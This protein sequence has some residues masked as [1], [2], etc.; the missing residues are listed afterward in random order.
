MLSYFTFRVESRTSFMTLTL[1]CHFRVLLRCTAWRPLGPMTGFIQ[2]FTGA[3]NKNK[4][5]GWYFLETSV[6]VLSVDRQ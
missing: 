2:N 5:H 3:D 6:E 4:D 1:C